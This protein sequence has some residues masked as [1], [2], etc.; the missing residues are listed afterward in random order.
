VNE[1]LA[2]AVEPSNRREQIGWSFYEWATAGFTTTVITVFIGPYLTT[3][4]KAAADSSGFVHPLGIAIR[5]GSFLP[6]LVSVSVLLQIVAMPILGAIADYAHRGKQMLAASAYLGALLTMGLY[7][8]QGTNYLLGGALYVLANLCYSA[9]VIF[10]NGFLPGIA[11]PDE[12][13]AVSSRSWALGALG[14]GILL[15][16]NLA[17]LSEA[18][19]FGL[20]EEMA[21]RIGLTSAGVWWAIFTVIPLI[22]LRAGLPIQKLPANESYLTVGFNQLSHTLGAVRAYRQTMLFLLAYLLYND[23]IQTV[24][25]L[26]SEFSQEEI[27]LDISTLTEVILMVQFVAFLGALSFERVAK[28]I[29]A[30]RALVTSLVIWTVMLIYTYAYMH[31]AAQVFAVGAI[32][33]VA[34]GGSQALSRSVY[35]QMIPKGQEAEYFSLYQVSAGGTSWLGPLFFGLAL[36]FTGSYRIAI[37]SLVIFFVLGLTLLARV[38]VSQ[39]ASEANRGYSS[40]PTP[41]TA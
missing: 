40:S 34:L 1:K 38:N 27:G 9:S 28:A 2:G 39:A 11:K 30:K 5:D 41:T 3:V 36:Q 26:W 35:S 23:G 18:A 12:R 13:D 6:Y 32:I 31:S 24:I 20:D 15:A 29:G 21:V 37:V 25:G 8:L 22:T 19:T 14:G 10:C 7:F 4:T 17:L 33:A 16:M